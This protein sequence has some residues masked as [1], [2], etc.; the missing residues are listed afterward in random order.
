MNSKSIKN[1][2]VSYKNPTN[3]YANVDRDITYWRKRTL[4]PK[5][6]KDIMLHPKENPNGYGNGTIP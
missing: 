5:K 2:E 3:L 6:W 4:D 1:I